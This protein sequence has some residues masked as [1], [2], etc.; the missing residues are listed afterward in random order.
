M[1]HLEA[2]N[3]ICEELDFTNM[4]VNTDTFFSILKEKQP[5]KFLL[6]IKLIIRNVLVYLRHKVMN[7]SY[8]HSEML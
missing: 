3:G 2:L 7:T 4:R 5:E 1:Y 6:K 8:E